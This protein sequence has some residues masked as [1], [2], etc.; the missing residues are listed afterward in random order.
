MVAKGHKNTNAPLIFENLGQFRGQKS[1][2]PLEISLEKAHYVVCPQKKNNIPHFQN[3][4]CINSYKMSSLLGFSKKKKPGCFVQ[5]RF[6][7]RSILYSIIGHSLF[8]QGYIFYIFFYILKFFPFLRQLHVSLRCL[9]IKGT[10]SRDF[11]LLVFFM[12]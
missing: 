2:G 3:Q 6:L 9:L 4:Q 1:L 8:Y 12:N 7:I 10:V 5:G 11:L